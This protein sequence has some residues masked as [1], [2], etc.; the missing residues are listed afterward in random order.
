MVERFL[1][2]R[3]K[4]DDPKQTKFVHSESQHDLSF[5]LKH[6]IVVI[7]RNCN[8]NKLTRKEQIHYG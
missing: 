1:G 4:R 2:K 3:C 6:C 8:S 5:V 7:H